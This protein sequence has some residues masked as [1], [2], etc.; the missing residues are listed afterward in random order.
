MD[1]IPARAPTQEQYQALNL[2]GDRPVLRTPCVV[3]SDDERPVEATVMVK[4]GHLYELRYE[5]TPG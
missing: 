1:R 5:F 3:Y 2:P 4:A